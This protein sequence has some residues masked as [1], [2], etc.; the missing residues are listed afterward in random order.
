VAADYAYHMEFDDDRIKH[1][2][3]VWNDV[4][5]LRQLGWS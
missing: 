3:K 1:M 4:H 2:T 5:S